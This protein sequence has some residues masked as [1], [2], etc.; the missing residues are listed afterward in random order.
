[1]CNEHKSDVLPVSAAV[2]QGSVLCPL[3]F[4]I[5]I[6]Q[7][8]H[9]VKKCALSTDDAAFNELVESI[10]SFVSTFFDRIR[11][12]TIGGRDNRNKSLQ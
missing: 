7:I 9:L 10:Q 3:L 1:M 12:N 2:P 8:S 11:L 4:S 6:N 5:Y